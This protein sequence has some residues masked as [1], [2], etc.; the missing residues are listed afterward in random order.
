MYDLMDDIRTCPEFVA[1]MGD[2][3]FC[4]AMWTAFANIYWYKK[5]DRSLPVGDQIIMMLTDSA[6]DHWGTSMRSMG[7]YIA[8]IR[9]VFHGKSE[10]YMD[11][12]MCNSGK[13]DYK[14]YGYVAPHLREAIFDLLGWVPVEDA[15]Y[16]DSNPVTTG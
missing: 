8:D 12:Y 13:P 11:W 3:Q 7:G 1:L 14:P 15:Y 10:S 6:D 9:N 5:I 16:L 2:E 4:I